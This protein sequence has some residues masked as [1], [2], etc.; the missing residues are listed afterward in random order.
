MSIRGKRR[1]GPAPCGLIESKHRLKST[2]LDEH[3]R[4]LL[5]EVE[6]ATGDFAQLIREQSLDADGRLGADL[7][8]DISH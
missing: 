8:L 2:D 7:M 5:D 4:L 6:S 3:L 1:R